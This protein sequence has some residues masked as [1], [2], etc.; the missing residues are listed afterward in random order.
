[1]SNAGQKVKVWDAPL[2]LFHWVLVVAIAI[3]FL[4]SEEDSALNNWHVLSG[5]L[6]AILLVFRLV[7]GLIGGEHSRFAAFIRP[8]RIGH[9]IS[10]LVGGEKADP[11]P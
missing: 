4:S 3:A 6:A 7:W 5:W 2:R 1:M 9:H 11:R 8:S 10:R